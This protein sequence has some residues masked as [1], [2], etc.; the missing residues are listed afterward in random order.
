MR[1]AKRHMPG[2]LARARGIAPYYRHNRYSF[3]TRFLIRRE[4]V[5]N[6][7]SSDSRRIHNRQSRSETGHP[8]EVGDVESQQVRYPV[9]LANRNQT[10]VMNLFPDYP[11]RPDQSFPLG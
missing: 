8:H 5:G 10:S 6:S 11:K 7:G 2:L 1:A 9:R 3:F 4:L